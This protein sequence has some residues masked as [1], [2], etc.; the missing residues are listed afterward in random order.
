MMMIQE[1]HRT[2]NPDFWLRQ[3]ETSDWRAGQYLAR[4]LRED[5]FFRELGDGS[6]LLML[7]ENG[8]LLAFCTYARRDD[9]PAPELTPWA[10]FVYTFPLQRGKR[11]MGKLLERVHALAKEDGYPCVYISTGET[12]L[13]EKYG[14][15]FWKTMKDSRGGESR[16]YRLHVRQMDYGKILGREVRGTVDRPLGSAH[17]EEPSLIYPVNYGCVD[18]VIGGDGEPQDVYILGPDEP[19]ETFSGRV[20]G[21]LHRLNDLEDKWIVTP[22][23]R[24]LPKEEI[25][26]AIAFQEQYYMGELYT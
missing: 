6:R 9:I 20:I 24:P 21:V 18:G 14:C 3:I 22:D 25:L 12:G 17:P 10:G 15:V 16:I 2:A 23:G 13:Y 8:Q 4:L 1:Y 19:L 7:T 5:R 11:R 26:A